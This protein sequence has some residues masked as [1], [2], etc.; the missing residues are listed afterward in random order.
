MEK[1]LRDKIVNHVI[2]LMKDEY[3]FSEIRDKVIKKFS[4]DSATASE[5]VKTSF[6]TVSFIDK[7]Q[8]IRKKSTILISFI[9]LFVALLCSGL[10]YLVFS[11]SKINLVLMHVVNAYI[12]GRM[13]LLFSAGER[14]IRLM[15]IASLATIINILLSEFSIFFFFL[16]K[17]ISERGYITENFLAFLKK[18]INLF[19][20]DYISVKS[21]YE[22]I[23]LLVAILISLSFFTKPKIKRIKK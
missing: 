19:F 18:A 20:T 12:I 16:K 15:I 4:I 9:S 21:S 17:E 22:F 7:N 14:S 10:Y 1:R 3:T 23:I 8:S 6:E 5:I 13:I 2:E 11:Y